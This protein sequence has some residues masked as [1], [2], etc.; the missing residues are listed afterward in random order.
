MPTYETVVDGKSRRIELTRISP[1]SF[2]A[3]VDGRTRKIKL[4]K[5][6]IRPKEVSVIEV[7]GKS[8]KVELSK[9]ELGKKVP[10]KVEET[11]FEVEVKIANIVQAMTSFEPTKP[12]AAKKTGTNRK[13]A[14]EGAVVA[15]MTGKIVKVK[16]KKGD[17]I[18]AG[19]ILCVIEAMKMENEISAPRAG[20]VQDVNVTDG[21]PV[22]EGETLFVII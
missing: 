13:A 11:R 1:E 20:T 3:I 17:R 10:V 14:A 19:Q 8:Y 18:K 16:V 9:S 15:P 22:N 21:T 7:D 4:Q 2:T 5:D 12:V 6:G